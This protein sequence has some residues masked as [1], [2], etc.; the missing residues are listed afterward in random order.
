MTFFKRYWWQMMWFSIGVI[1]T[2]LMDYFDF[3]VPHD[4]GF[5]S[6]TTTPPWYDDAWHWSKV[7]ML[8]SFGMGMIPRDKP[9]LILLAVFGALNS[10]FHGLVYHHILKKL[11]RRNG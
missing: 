9:K 7:L 6:L 5:W 10:L 11:G 8:A 1:F 4:S 2:A 3:Q